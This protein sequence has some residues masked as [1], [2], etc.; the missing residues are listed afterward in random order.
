METVV[1][2]PARLLSFLSLCGFTPMSDCRGLRSKPRHQRGLGDHT[3]LSGAHLRRPR[4]EVGCSRGSFHLCIFPPFL[5]YVLWL[6][7][8][9]ATKLAHRLR[10]RSPGARSR[11]RRRLPG[12]SGSST[13][14]NWFS[15]QLNSS[16]CVSQSPGAPQGFRTLVLCCYSDRQTTSL[17]RFGGS[18]T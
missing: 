3:D 18:A 4:S 6:S 1:F 7:E 15:G 2:F 5:P 9:T 16:T 14:A 10:V 13:C 11:G 12:G 8:S 17:I